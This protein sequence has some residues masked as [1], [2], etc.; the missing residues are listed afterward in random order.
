[1]KTVKSDKA[2][3]SLWSTGRRAITA[4]VGQLTNNASEIMRIVSATFR[5]EGHRLT[6]RITVARTRR[7]PTTSSASP[8]TSV[9]R[10]PLISL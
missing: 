5:E 7:Y 3:K 4:K 8:T 2:L 6:Y 9:S 10:S 1:M